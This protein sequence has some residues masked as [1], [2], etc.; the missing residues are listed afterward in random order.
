MRGAQPT[1][2]IAGRYEIDG[3][4]GEGG[5]GCVYGARDRRLGGRE[6]AVK[7]LI[8]SEGIGRSG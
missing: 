7:V 6:V 3:V 1:S 5:M 4:I 8:A 2:P